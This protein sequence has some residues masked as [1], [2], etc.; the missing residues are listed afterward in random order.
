MNIEHTASPTCEGTLIPS[1]VHAVYELGICDQFPR[2]FSVRHKIDLMMTGIPNM[3]ILK[4]DRIQMEDPITR[5]VQVADNC[6]LITTR[7]Q[8]EPWRY[9]AETWTTC[10]SVASSS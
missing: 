1:R 4:Y 2:V 3:H 5:S 9:T 7:P 10:M 6:Y 8:D